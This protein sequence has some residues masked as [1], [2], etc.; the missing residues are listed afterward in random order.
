MPVQDK[1]PYYHLGSVQH[2]EAAIDE[3]ILKL[4]SLDPV[5]KYMRPCHTFSALMHEL[6]NVNAEKLEEVL[7]AGRAITSLRT[8]RNALRCMVADVAC[9]TGKGQTAGLFARS[10]YATS[11][12]LEPTSLAHNALNAYATARAPSPGT[13]TYYTNCHSSSIAERTPI[14]T[15]TIYSVHRPQHIGR[16]LDQRAGPG[17]AGH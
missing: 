2:Y 15:I 11:L 16:V 17:A 6:R 9:R 8:Q 1:P 14:P 3:Q 12:P 10:L 7:A 13:D 4:Q 5:L